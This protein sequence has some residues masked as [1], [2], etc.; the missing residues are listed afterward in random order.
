MVTFA[1]HDT[2]FCAEIVGLQKLASLGMV[3]FAT[4]AK[5][6]QKSVPRLSVCKTSLAREWLLSLNTIQNY[7]PKLSVCKN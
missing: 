4:F 5:Y 1:K 3:T 6:D 2:K 7:V